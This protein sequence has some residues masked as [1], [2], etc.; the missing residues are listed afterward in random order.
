M[1]K[2]LIYSLGVLLLAGL[3]VFQSCS[4]TETAAPA[5]V[6]TS[7]TTGFDGS[8]NTFSGH[9]NDTLKLD[10]TVTAEGIFKTLTIT[11]NSGNTLLEEA[12]PSGNDQLKEYTTTYNYVLSADNVGSDVTLTIAS[13]DEDSKSGEA[14]VTVT[15]T[16][17][18]PA[19]IKY[20]ARLLYA[21]LQDK[22]SKTFFSTD[23]GMTYSRQD[24]EGTTD[25]VSPKIDFGY[26]F[27]NT[28]NASIANPATYPSAMGDLSSWGTKNKTKL[29]LTAMP[30]EHYDQ[31]TNNEELEH[32]YGMTDMTDA[33]GVVTKLAVGNMVAFQLDDAKGATHGFFVV[34]TIEGTWDSGDYIEI[35]VVIAGK[36]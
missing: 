19:V 2:T 20:S 12:R 32:H 7:S 22:S 21:P 13:M 16:K 35:D 25:P 33:K 10:I 28:D 1:K 36:E 29:K 8:N 18:P 15:T 11:D 24:V 26:Y 6:V 5:V 23:D 3:M 4:K 34:K 31:I 17:M 27:G 14:T 30:A 9:P